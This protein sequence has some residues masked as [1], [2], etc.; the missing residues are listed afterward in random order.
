MKRL[1]Y[2]VA[3]ALALTASFSWAQVPV[4]NNNAQISWPVP[5]VMA[6]GAALDPVLIFGYDLRAC[7]EVAC[8]PTPPIIKRVPPNPTT[9]KLS[10]VGVLTDGQWFL[11]YRVLHVNGNASG[12]APAREIQVSTDAPAT[13]TAPL[14]ITPVPVSLVPVPPYLAAGGAY[15]QQ[16]FAQIDGARNTLLDGSHVNDPPATPIVPPP[17]GFPLPVPPPAN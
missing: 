9:A 1:S 15:E 4:V 16:L 10:D 12:F 6:S 13:P 11:S 3:A 17:G 5:K 14:T 2:L 8:T 7:K